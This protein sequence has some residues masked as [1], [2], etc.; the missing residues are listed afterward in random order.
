VTG[1]SIVPEETP[2]TAPYWA[3][4][5][6]GRVALQRCVDCGLLWHPPSPT[7]PADPMHDV[8]WVDA[9]GRASLVTYT[10]VRHAA[11]AAV[12]DRLPYLVA[13]VRLVE[14]P[15]LV[16]SLADVDEAD[17]VRGMDVQLGLGST[18]GGLELPVARPVR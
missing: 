2:L 7:C 14:G 16:C 8:E 18:P 17:L 4:A 9:S 15:T 10:S 6:A 1:P 3:T 12:A 11:H 13:L 5:R